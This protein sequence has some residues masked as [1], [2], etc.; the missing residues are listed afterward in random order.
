MKLIPQKRAATTSSRACQLGHPFQGLPKEN[1]TQV[2]SS[3]DNLASSLPLHLKLPFPLPVSHVP[4]QAALCI[5]AV[6]SQLF[7]PQ[8]QLTS[9][10]F[11]CILSSPRVMFTSGSF[12]VARESKPSDK[13]PPCDKESPAFNLDFYLFIYFFTSSACV[14]CLHVCL[15]TMCIS[16]VQ[17]GQ[18]RATAPLEL[19]LQF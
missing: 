13:E 11:W 14:F 1:N 9:V 12:S 7:Y 8:D 10:Y 17:S 19:E 4:W 5:S 2:T 15:C 18:K 16:D 3:V 6:A